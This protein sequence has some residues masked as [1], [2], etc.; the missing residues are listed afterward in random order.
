MLLQLL[1]FY[2]QIKEKYYSWCRNPLTKKDEETWPASLLLNTAQDNATDTLAQLYPQL[3]KLM[4]HMLK[5]TAMAHVINCSSKLTEKGMH[6]S[7]I[8]SSYS[9]YANYIL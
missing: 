8:N 4:L 6:K 9:T 5:N 3:Q 1:T 7:P 2:K